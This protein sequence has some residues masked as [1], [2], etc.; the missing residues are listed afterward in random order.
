MIRRPP[1]ST[2]TDT[3][4]PYTTLFRSLEGKAIKSV[5]SPDGIVVVAPEAEPRKTTNSSYDKLFKIGPPHRPVSSTAWEPASASSWS[6]TLSHAPNPLA[7][8]PGGC[9]SS[10]MGPD[11]QGGSKALVRFRSEPPVLPFH[12]SCQP[13][14]E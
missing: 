13:N 3:L 12:W 7:R 10:L 5:R 6:A 1:R 4:F 8:G 9:R 2:R 14:S 11:R